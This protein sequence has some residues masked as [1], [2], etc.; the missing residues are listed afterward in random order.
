MTK[1][2]LH[3]TPRHS[4]LYS[5]S[6]VGVIFPSGDHLPSTLLGIICRPVH[7]VRLYLTVTSTVAVGDWCISILAVVFNDWRTPILIF[8]MFPHAPAV[9]SMIVVLFDR[10]HSSFWNFISAIPID[11]INLLNAEVHTT[12]K[13]N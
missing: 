12:R 2:Q 8:L 1:N 5:L 7:V 11:I 3:S 13:S 10:G 6:F 9:V 4:L